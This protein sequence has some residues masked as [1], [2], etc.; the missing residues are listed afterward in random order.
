MSSWSLEGMTLPSSLQ[1]FIAHEQ[2]E[3]LNASKNLA[4]D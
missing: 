2:G 3:H 4:A 1:S